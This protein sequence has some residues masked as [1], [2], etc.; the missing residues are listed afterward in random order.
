MK[1]MCYVQKPIV[2]VIVNKIHNNASFH[3]PGTVDLDRWVMV[4]LRLC[5]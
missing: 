4:C 5:M 3:M 1:I 2:L